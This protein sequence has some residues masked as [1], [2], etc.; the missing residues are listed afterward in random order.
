M[1]FERPSTNYELVDFGQGRKLELFGG[2]LIDRPSPAAEGAS[3]ACPESV[4][5]SAARFDRFAADRGEWRAGAGLTPLPERWQIRHRQFVLEL[6]ATPAGQ[7][8][9]FPE[10][11]ANWDWLTEQISA[12][13]QPVTLLNLF[14]Y[15]GASSLAAA[16]AGAEVTHVDAARNIVAW[17]RRNA[18]LS[19]LAQ[20]PIRWIVDDAVTFVRRELKRGRHYDWIVLDP[21]SYGHGAQGQ[22]WKL[23]DDLEPLLNDCVRLR[24][25]RLGGLLLTCHTPGFGPRELRELLVRAAGLGEV[26]S[27]PLVL[28]SRDGRLLA[29]GAMA[30]MVVRSVF[31]P[32]TDR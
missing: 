31:A 3:K 8:G 32:E 15:T 11:V 14:A 27:Q 10:Q 9:V 1:H 16:A 23:A 21:P 4:W 19:S 28:E 7:L 13:A 24:S 22:S 25:S 2:H 30:R 12:A 29:G 5:A 20:A 6:R 17:A 26:E 18:E